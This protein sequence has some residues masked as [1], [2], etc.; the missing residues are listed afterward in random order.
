MQKIYT[1]QG[2]LDKEERSWKNQFLKLQTI[3]QS[4]SNQSWMDKEKKRNIDQ[5]NWKKK[6]SPEITHS[7]QFSCSVM[8]ISLWPHGLQHAS[9]P[10][11]SSTPGACSNSCP[12]RDGDA[13]QQS[14]PLSSPSPN[15]FNFSQHQSVFQRVCSSHQVAKVLEFHFHHQSFQWISRADFL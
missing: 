9:L 8:S 6:K 10:C 2:N 11:P 1:S 4:F 3:L 14:H 5:Y 12:Y 15:V 7:V 13:I